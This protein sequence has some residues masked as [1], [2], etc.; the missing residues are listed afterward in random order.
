M[1]ASTG[2]WMNVCSAVSP[3]VRCSVALRS[4]GVVGLS[5]VSQLMTRESSMSCRECSEGEY[6]AER[7]DVFKTA[8][9]LIKELDWGDDVEVT[10]SDV[11]L[12]AR[13]LCGET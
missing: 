8:F 1:T 11:E 7:R 13:F 9:A 6:W 2:L 5:S 12:V 10:P 4:A 3:G